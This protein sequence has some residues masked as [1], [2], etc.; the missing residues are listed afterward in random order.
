[1]VAV[2]PADT[3]TVATLDGGGGRGGSPTRQVSEDRVG[4]PP[5]KPTDGEGA[6]KSGRCYLSQAGQSRQLIPASSFSS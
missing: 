4:L 3:I 1:M 2:G 5:R 6:V